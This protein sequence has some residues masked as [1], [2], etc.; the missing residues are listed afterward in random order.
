VIAKVCLRSDD[1]EEYDEGVMYLDSTDLEL[2][3]DEVDQLVGI[4]FPGIEV[5][6]NAIIR[7]AKI[8]FYVERTDIAPTQLVIS[9]I[10][11]ANP[12]TFVPTP[13]DLSKRPRTDQKVPWNPEPWTRNE[14]VESPL[15][16]EIVQHLVNL[17]EWHFGNAMGF[18]MEGKGIRTATAY[19]GNIHYG[20]YIEIQYEKVAT[21]SSAAGQ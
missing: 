16:T 14:L 19:D 6:R 13:Y 10:D 4:R 8:C 2:T 20:P 3:W 1:V 15:C 9:G 7:S 18:V 5:P 17:P 21:D 12:K 11:D